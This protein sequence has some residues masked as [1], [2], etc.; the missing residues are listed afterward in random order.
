ML[1]V[2]DVAT[3]FRVHPATVYRWIHQGDLPAYR[4]G[5]PYTPGDGAT[6]ALRIPE[7]V[8]NSTDAPTAA[9]EAA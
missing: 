6:G 2:R 4:N 5:R 7:S 8:L 1:R 3:H 9:K